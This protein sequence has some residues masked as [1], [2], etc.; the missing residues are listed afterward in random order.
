MHLKTAAASLLLLGLSLSA[1]RGQTPG[2]LVTYVVSPHDADPSVN[3][4]LNGNI[5]T[6]APN[7]SEAA[8]LLVFLPGTGGTPSGVRTFL[9]TAALDGYRVIGLMYDDADAVNVV[10]PRNP[11]PSCSEQFRQKRIY[12]DPVTSVID[13]LPSE[14]IGSRLVH[15]LSYLSRTHPKDGWDAY[16]TGGAPNWARIAFAGHSQGAG[17]AAFIAKDH[18]L[19]RVILFSSPWDFQAPARL[20][21]WLSKP[22][23]TPVS[24]WFGVYHV[25]E[26][27]AGLISRAYAALQIPTANIRPLSLEPRHPPGT[28][29]L[30]RM[31]YHVSVI[32]DG[33]TPL[34]SDGTPSY[35]PDW[36]FLLG[37]VSSPKM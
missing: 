23:A 12:G 10:C 32:G 17:M 15:L 1:A 22:P 37:R 5:V 21:S 16:L 20:S 34:S 2:N 25:N 24:R 4:F 36:L 11:N 9:A 13:D 18:P 26:P 27:M 8:P 33:T 14:S 35:L 29:R 3:R 30:G 19:Y 6:F 28:D 7:V 31:I